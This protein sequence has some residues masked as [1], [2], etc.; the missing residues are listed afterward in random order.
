MHDCVHCDMCSCQPISILHS[1]DVHN[2]VRHLYHSFNPIY[3]LWIQGTIL[4]SLDTV[5]ILDITNYS[6]LYRPN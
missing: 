3:N 5:D 1:V 4:D 2:H 6:C